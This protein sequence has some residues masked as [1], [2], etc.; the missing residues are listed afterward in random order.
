MLAGPRWVDTSSSALFS[1]RAKRPSMQSTSKGERSFSFQ[2]IATNFNLGIGCLRTAAT[3]LASR[4]TPLQCA[5]YGGHIGCMSFLLQHG[6]DVNSHDREV[7]PLSERK[8]MSRLIEQVFDATQC[9]HHD[10]G[11]YT[12]ALGL[13]DRE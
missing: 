7:Q 2:L 3:D 13:L 12:A 8:P 1:S 11:H 9:A 6:A 5:T 4:R 10:A